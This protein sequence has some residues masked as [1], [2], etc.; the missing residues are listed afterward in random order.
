M[1]YVR[2]TWAAAVAAIAIGACA[3]ATEQSQVGAPESATTLVVKNNNW[4][5]VVIY[6]MRGAMRTRLG[7]VTSMNSA[8]FRLSDT[9]MSGTGGVRIVADPIGSARTYTSP[10]ITVTPGAQ[11]ELQVQNQISISNYAVYR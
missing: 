8:R 4:Q 5:E 11:V 10:A 1:K 7:S 6:V 9:M 3:P 2:S